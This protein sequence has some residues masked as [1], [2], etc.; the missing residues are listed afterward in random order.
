MR[1]RFMWQ[2]GF[3]FFCWSFGLDPPPP[4]ELESPAPFNIKWLLVNLENITKP[5]VARKLL[6]KSDL[7]LVKKGVHVM[8]RKI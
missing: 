2:A 1:S 3:F 4:S 8:K 5:P 6:F 7:I